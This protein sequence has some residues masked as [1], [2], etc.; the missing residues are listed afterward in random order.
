MKKWHFPII[1]KCGM[2]QRS[3]GWWAEVMVFSNWAASKRWL[4]KYSE[5]KIRIPANMQLH[6]YSELNFTTAAVIIL[7]CRSNTSKMWKI[8]FRMNFKNVIEITSVADV[9]LGYS[10]HSE[11]FVFNVK[12][13]PSHSVTCA[14]IH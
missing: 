6:T 4:E 11:G 9:D 2:C 13:V 10:A 7:L 5:V 3:W 12:H 1:P 14:L 8:K